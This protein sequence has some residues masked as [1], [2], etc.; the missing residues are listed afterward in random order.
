M[1]ATHSLSCNII[2]QQLSEALFFVWQT[3]WE[4][5][6]NT[7]NL[8][9]TALASS[10]IIRAWFARNTS[11]FHIIVIFKIP[12]FSGLVLNFFEGGFVKKKKVSLKGRKNIGQAAHTMHCT[13]LKQ[14][15]NN[16]F[17]FKLEN[18]EERIPKYAKYSIY[19]SLRTQKHFHQL[20][21]GVG[22]WAKK[23]HQIF[24]FFFFFFFSPQC[25]WVHTTVRG[26]CLFNVT[27]KETCQYNQQG[28]SHLLICS[29]VTSVQ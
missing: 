7:S 14:L 3:T 11:C 4:S 16:L 28:F 1:K 23:R 9:A 26:N 5:H 12:S 6:A 15:P 29:F 17:F 25:A 8:T 18:T 27:G 21:L 20:T 22:G 19:P 2:F 13:L 10:V 24:T